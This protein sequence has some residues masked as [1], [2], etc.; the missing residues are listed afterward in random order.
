MDDTTILFRRDG[1]TPKTIVLGNLN[2]VTGKLEAFIDQGID[3]ASVY[4][5]HASQRNGCSE[6][7]RGT[8]KELAMCTVLVITGLLVLA[9]CAS[10]RCADRNRM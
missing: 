2:R 4:S 10:R 9:R 6:V 1:K 5:L 3:I 7:A 8:K